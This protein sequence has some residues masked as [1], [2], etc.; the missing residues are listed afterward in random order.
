MEKLTNEQ[1]EK[2]VTEYSRGM[3]FRGYTAEEIFRLG[4][5]KALEIAGIDIPEIVH[6]DNA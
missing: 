4:M 1:V 5:L 3:E 2:M 6:P